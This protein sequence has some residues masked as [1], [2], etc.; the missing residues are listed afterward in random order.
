MPAADFG[1]ELFY[2]SKEQARVL[3]CIIVAMTWK[4]NQSPF[5]RIKTFD[6]TTG[7]FAGTIENVRP[8][9]LHKTFEAAS[10]ENNEQWHQSD[11]DPTKSNG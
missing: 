3:R 10:K 11:C 6:N 9:E 7:D 4:P 5:Y 2:Y 1:T 8:E